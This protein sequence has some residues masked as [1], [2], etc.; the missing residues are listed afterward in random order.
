MCVYSYIYI[1]MY[2][3]QH[4]VHHDYCHDAH[5]DVHIM[6]ALLVGISK[7]EA[8]APRRAEVPCVVCSIEPSIRIE[9][10]HLT[11]SLNLAESLN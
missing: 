5:F 6:R 7:L 2:N 10:L 9:S 1:Y 8:S 4:V 3:I 11:E